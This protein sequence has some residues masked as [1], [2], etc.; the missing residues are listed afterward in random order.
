MLES[1]HFLHHLPPPPLWLNICSVVSSFVI[2]KVAVPWMGHYVYL[3]RKAQAVTVH[4]GTPYGVLLM[5]IFPSWNCSWSVDLLRERVLSCQPYSWEAH[6]CG[7]CWGR[8]NCLYQLFCILANKELPLPSH[9]A[10][11]TV[12]KWKKEKKTAQK[13]LSVCK[14]VYPENDLSKTLA[15]SALSV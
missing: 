11:P 15:A 10:S 2:D 5:F 4:P 8:G 1:S 3:S 9:L 12:W 13:A 6:F 14:N 7:S